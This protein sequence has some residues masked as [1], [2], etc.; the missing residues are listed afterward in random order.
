M[1]SVDEK[2][3]GKRQLANVVCISKINRVG[4][5]AWKRWLSHYC[6][7]NAHIEHYWDESL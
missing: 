6:D 2:H 4:L 1:N 3:T 7:V 5:Q